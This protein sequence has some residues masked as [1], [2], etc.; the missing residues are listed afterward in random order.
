[1]KKRWFITVLC[2]F[3]LLTLLN[4][5][6][7]S[8]L[9]DKAN[10]QDYAPPQAAPGNGVVE[11]GAAEDAVMG[12]MAFSPSET[13]SPISGLMIPAAEP[14]GRKIIWRVELEAE[15]LEFDPFLSELEKAVREYDGYLEGSSVSGN[16]I[17]YSSNRYGSLTIRIPS[18][19]LDSF[20]GQVGQLC[21]VTHT[22]KSSEDVTLDYVDVQARI[23]ALTT[24][25]E[26][27]LA[28]L[29][30][31]QDLESVIQL[32]SRLSEVRYQLES[33]HSMK[34]RYD[35]LI[36]YS[37]VTLSV[38][39]VQRVTVVPDQ[40]VWQ[41]I[42]AGWSNTMYRLKTGL[43]DF[44]VWFVV[45]LPYLLIWAAFA[46]VIVWIS[47]RSAKKRQTQKLSARF[48]PP[49]EKTAPSKKP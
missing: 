17:T 39:E 21:T 4:G 36:D 43:V 12:D 38:R 23:E 46:G 32:E 15:T 35:S 20:L 27:L 49:E 44:F 40:S 3:V 24:E 28:L 14:A 8:S 41:R 42:G 18:N 2:I 45:N 9:T 22:N 29:E 34:N 6:S 16:A 48:V 25:Q 7:A 1:M 47:L 5:C 10:T 13:D 37:T 30:S 11:N 26:R 31:A 33:Y 19:R